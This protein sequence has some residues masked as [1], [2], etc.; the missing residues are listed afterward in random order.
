[1]LRIEKKDKYFAEFKWVL[2][3]ISKDDSRRIGLTM[4]LIEGDGVVKTIVCC[5]GHNLNRFT[6][7]DNSN[8]YKAG[9]YEVVLNNNKAVLLQPDECGMQYPDYKRVIPGKKNLKFLF[10]EE[11][12]KTS[13]EKFLSLNCSLVMFNLA[14]CGQILTNFDKVEKGIAGLGGEVKFYSHGD[15]PCGPVYFE[16]RNMNG[17]VMPFACSNK[18]ILNKIEE[19]RLKERTK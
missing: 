8:I 12:Q 19:L 15:N 18:E 6:I 10:K 7:E 13:S 5:D 9:L 17:V 3:A 14:V 4:L 11:L 2:Q 1:M 16:V